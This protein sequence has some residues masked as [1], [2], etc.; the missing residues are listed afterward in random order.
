MPLHTRAT[1]SI[2]VNAPARTAYMFFTPAGEELWVRGWAPRYVNPAD[3]ATRQGMVFCTG[4]GDDF[5]VWTLLDFDR[6]TLR[7]LYVR[8]TP[9]SRTGTVE[10]VCTALD[11]SRTRVEVTYTLT[12]LSPDGERLLEGFEGP[13]F[14]AMIDGWAADIDRRLPQLLAAR[15]R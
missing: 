4:Q 5:T 9:A 7:S 15:I 14:A 8:C 3:G 11:D 12:A 10:V 13:A 2:V 6:Q 1:H